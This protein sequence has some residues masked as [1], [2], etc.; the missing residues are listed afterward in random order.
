MPGEA[1]LGMAGDDDPGPAVSGGRVADL[2]GGPAEDLLEQPERM[3]KI[4]TP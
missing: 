3:L 2:R 4:E 1:Q